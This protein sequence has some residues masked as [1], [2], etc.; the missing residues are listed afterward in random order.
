MSL[1]SSLAHLFHP[2]RSN[3]HRPKILHPE[4]FIALTFIV[5]IFSAGFL[6]VVKLTQ[7]A[8]QQGSVLGYASNITASDVVTQT[9][10]ERAKAGLGAL[11]TNSKLNQA[12]LAKAQ[13][14]FDKQF[15]AHVAP[16]GTQPWEFFKKA[17]YRYSVAGENLA[18][19]FSNSNEMMAAWMASPTHKANIV[20]SRYKEIGVAVVDGTLLGTQTTLVVQLFGTPQQ[21]TADILSDTKKAQQVAQVPSQPSPAKDVKTAPAAQPED[22]IGFAEPSTDQP[23]TVI[24]RGVLGSEG[25]A[26]SSLRAPALFSPLQMSKLFFLAIIF[27]LV[28][29]LLYDGAITGHRNTVRLVGRNFAHVIMFLIVA[30]LLIVFKAGVVG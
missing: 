13:Y 23:D 5:V 1:A 3:N 24:G 4:A 26:L 10:E 22:T 15:W 29:T 17:N 28:M 11:T 20:N 2:R 8:K 27:M 21:G 12:A 7:W 14:M 30:Y 18:R 9:N 6:P 16:D 25:F 19:D